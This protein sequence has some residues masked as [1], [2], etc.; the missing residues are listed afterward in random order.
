VG[1]GLAEA[2]AVVA[3]SAWMQ[4]RLKEIYG[5]NGYSWVIYNG[6]TPALFNPHITKEPY[7]LSVGRLWDSGKQ[8][9]L[10]CREGLPLDC[11]LAGSDRH[12]EAS[13]RLE[14]QLKGTIPRLHF[15]GPQTQDQ[16]RQLYGKASIYAATSRYEPFGLAPL[17]AALS[18]CALVM[19]DIPSFRELWDG[20]GC[21]FRHN[22]AQDL[23]AQMELLCEQPEKRR[24]L[25]NRAYQRARTVFN[26]ERMVDQYLQLYSE[27]ARVSALAA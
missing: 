19:N 24:E 27:T 17:E 3:P 10:L 21:F 7:L 4:A 18:R 12:P 13:H 2:T 14:A 23:F 6:R 22:S 1:R 25:A 5:L 9:T 8:V 26:A 16:L 20:A 11:H 15:K